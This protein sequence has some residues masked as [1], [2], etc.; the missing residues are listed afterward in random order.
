MPDRV[1]NDAFFS[2]TASPPPQPIVEE[3]RFYPT[4][5]RPPPRPSFVKDVA[6]S[7]VKLGGV[8]FVVGWMGILV[9]QGL[10]SQIVAGAPLF[11]EPAKVGAAIALS[12][13]LSVRLLLL[14]LPL[15]AGMG[16]AFGVFEHWLT[17][18]GE[19]AGS[20][21][22]RVAFHALSTA[23]SMAAF[24]ALE[25]DPDVRLRWAATLPATLL[26][27]ANNGM[28]LVL[29]LLSLA[30]PALGEVATWWSAGVTAALGLALLAI[31]VQPDAFRRLVAR[32]ARRFIPAMRAA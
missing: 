11:E 29:A 28:A 18:A 3:Q 30:L 16:A 19:D 14:R 26:H 17:Y 4:P 6:R 8:L 25:A 20:Y 2:R 27:A 23:A 24:T 10:F 32:L 21:T 9:Q 15:A 5:E 7:P 12:G 31:V 1:E 22:L 13:L